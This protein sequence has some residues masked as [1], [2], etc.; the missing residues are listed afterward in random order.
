[1]IRIG[2]HWKM[3]FWDEKEKTLRKGLRTFTARSY[4][5]RKKNS[6]QEK[7]QEYDVHIFRE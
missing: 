6:N 2:V 1:M 3:A 7:L 5:M 4:L